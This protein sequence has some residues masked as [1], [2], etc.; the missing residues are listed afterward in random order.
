MKKDRPPL[1]ERLKASLEDIALY[2]AGEKQLVETKLMIPE[3]PKAYSPNDVVAVRSKLGMS[4]ASLAGFM[5]VSIKTIQGWEQGLRT[6][7][8]VASRLLQMIEEPDPFL[9][10]LQ[11]RS[12]SQCRTSA[13]G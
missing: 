7:S 9:I 5:H 12:A 3:P 2:A 8:G 6:P 4:Q 1:F 13:A 11:T 10:S